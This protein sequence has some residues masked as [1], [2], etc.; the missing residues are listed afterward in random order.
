M[1]SS[2]TAGP[3]L[4]TLVSATLIPVAAGAQDD[5]LFVTGD[6]VGIGT[7]TPATD[8]HLSTDNT[9][10]IRLEQ[11]AS[12]GLTP[13]T[14]D[15]A[16]NETGFRVRDVTH[17]GKVPFRIAP[18]APTGT[19]EIAASGKVGLGTASPEGYLEVSTTGTIGSRKMLQLV[20]NGQLNFSLARTDGSAA[21]WSFTHNGSQFNFSKAGTGANEFAIFDDGDVEARGTITGNVANPS[22]RAKKTDLAPLDP[23]QVLEQVVGLPLYRWRYRENDEGRLHIGPMAEDFNAGLGVGDAERIFLVDANGA[24]LAAI[25]GLYRLLE[26]ERAERDAL[27]EENARLAVR[28]AAVEELTLSTLQQER[29]I[30]TQERLL[31]DLETRLAAFGSERSGRPA[32]AQ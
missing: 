4:A 28:L 22:A 24:A 3:L 9:P 18:D 12:G 26:A 16:G 19:V 23:G 20:N 32:A 31:A 25:Q 21:I 10:E 30:A 27:R 2:R 15:L 5:V 11:N 1:A 8:L 7:A 6:K 29:I 13:Q 14:W 17:G